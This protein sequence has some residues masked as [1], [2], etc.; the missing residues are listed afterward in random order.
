MPTA[1]SRSRPTDARVRR[2]S[3]ARPARRPYPKRALRRTELERL[4]DLVDRAWAG[5]AWHG[6]S[7]LEALDGVT[8]ADAAAR[9]IER[10]H[11]IGEL[12]LHM[13]RWKRA[14]ATRLG[15][16]PD[17]PGEAEN[18][19]EFRAR[20]WRSALAGLRR[21]HEAVR[22]AISRLAPERLEEPAVPGGTACFLQ[23]HGIVHH[24]LWH[25]G[26]ILVLRRAL[27]SRGR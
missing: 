14:V 8:A 21:A 13:A 1:R 3:P 25:A 15:G 19:P 20:E 12:V 24:D 11:T 18:F 6:S 10:S 26:Q 4:I 27:E 16:Q 7:V 9:P 22:A 2:A 5:Y 17:A 23:A